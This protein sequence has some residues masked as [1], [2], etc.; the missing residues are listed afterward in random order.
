MSKFFPKLS[1]R[2]TKDSKLARRTRPVTDED[3]DEMIEGLRDTSASLQPVE[4]RGAE[5]GDTVTINVQGKFVDAPDEEDI[6]A[7][8]IE[9]VLGGEGVQQE[10]T[11]NL[12][13][14][15]PDDTKNFPSHLP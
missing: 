11:D 1:S 4:D 3:V 10:F 13:N 15:K 14:T 8:D 12:Q 9:V 7:D 2:S 5:P 6:K